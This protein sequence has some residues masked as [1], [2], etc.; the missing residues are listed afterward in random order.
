MGVAGVVTW[1]IDAI[2]EGFLVFALYS[3]SELIEHYAERYASRK[4]TGLRELL[5]SKVSV[6]VG[7]G[8]IEKDLDDVDVG[9][10][11]LVKPGDTVPADG[12]IVDGEAVF[13]TS[14]ITGESEPRYLRKGDHVE[15]GYV[16]KGGLVRVRILRRPDESILQLLVMEAERSLA[17]KASLQRFIERFSQPYTILVL[18]LFGLATLLLTP[19]RAL[20]ILLA[21]CPSAFIISSGTSTA[22]TI[23]V[24]ARRTI[25]ARGGLSLENTYR[26][27]IVVFDKTGTV[28][29]G[30]LRVTRAV[31]I[32]GFSEKEILQLAGG[33]A[34]ASNHPVAQAI[35]EHSDMIPFSA[36]EYPGKGVKAVVDG[37]TVY[38][39]SKEFFKE[40][41]ITVND[42]GCGVGEREVFVS[43]DGCLAG[44]LCLGEE[45]SGD[46]REIV[47][48]LKKMGLEIVIA[49]GDTSDR[50]EK[51]ARFLGIDKYYAELSPSDK[52]KLVKDLRRKYGY[53]AMVGDG[54]ND[55]E[56]LAEAD[57]GIAV[58]SL[59][60]V[61]SIAD[62]VLPKGINGLP[63]LFRYARK[64]M[65]S[66][67]TSIALALAIKLGVI[68]MGLMGLLPLW[69]I[70]GIGDDGSTLVAL[71]VIGYLV[72]RR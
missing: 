6:Q 38:I 19:Y 21:G 4:L 53:V 70:V 36:E 65:L 25:V 66:I 60:V 61:S 55:L 44:V 5:P 62:V 29:L 40:L 67:Y 72:S 11:V 41:G 10:I 23:A 28:T 2:L 12:V 63:L 1:Y 47:S 24:L 13:D 3:I 58:G 39:G 64:Y 8:I 45:L 33:A 32:N 26:A 17:R 57:V 16:N 37:K 56:A 49:S 52:K 9:D 14:Y 7:N 71:S 48:I 43:I 31:A 18:V 15:S 51:V 54:I 42:V 46:A 22:L 27:R 30:K 68:T 50:V 59:N 35:A 34:K 20:A 69:A